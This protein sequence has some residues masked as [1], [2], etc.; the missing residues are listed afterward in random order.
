[1]L[2]DLS[3]VMWGSMQRSQDLAPGNLA[4]ESSLSYLTVCGGGARGTLSSWWSQTEVLPLWAP[5]PLSS[6]WLPLSWKTPWKMSVCWRLM[7][8]FIGLNCCKCL[9]LRVEG[10]EI[11]P[12]EEE[13]SRVGRELKQLLINTCW[14]FDHFNRTD[15]SWASNSGWGEMKKTSGSLRCSGCSHFLPLWNKKLRV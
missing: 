2:G 14:G 8:L 15:L 11:G 10:V 7:M 6:H 4:A 3:W 9:S 5:L 1:M 12:P 13:P